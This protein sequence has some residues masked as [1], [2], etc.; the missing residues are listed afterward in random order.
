[1]GRILIVGDEATIDK[2]LASN[3]EQDEH[4]VSHALGIEEAR[5]AIA[6]NQY[7]AILTDHKMPDGGGLE[8]LA[9]ALDADPDISVILFTT[10]ANLEFAAEGLRKGAFNF[11]AKH[12]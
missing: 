4:V 7:E 11:L 2:I 3:L 5:Q 10:D 8:V 1:M 9:T 12:S 6:S